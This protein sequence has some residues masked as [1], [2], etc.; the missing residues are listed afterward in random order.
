MAACRGCNVLF[1]GTVDTRAFLEQ[2][3]R[4]LAGAER[5]LLRTAYTQ[6][7]K[8]PGCADEDGNPLMETRAVKCCTSP[9]DAT[10][11]ITAFAFW[12]ST[13]TSP[14]RHHVDA[15][16][17]SDVELPTAPAIERCYDRGSSLYPA[18][19]HGLGRSPLAVTD[20]GEAAHRIARAAGAAST[21]TVTATTLPGQSC[22]TLPR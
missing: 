15:L 1:D 6:Y 21:A 22:P 17:R 16:R 20:S 19:A 2:K 11:P 18:Q 4:S 3:P 14:V 7:L 10:A 13:P 8:A 12:P 9:T 5:E